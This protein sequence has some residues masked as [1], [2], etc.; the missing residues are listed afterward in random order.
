M[1]RRLFNF[2]TVRRLARHLFAIGS[3][4]LLVAASA[5]WLESYFYGHGLWF[6]G[7]TRAVSIV[8]NRGGCVVYCTGPITY[9]PRWSRRDAASWPASYDQL[10]DRHALGF[11]F[12]LAKPLSSRGPAYGF[13]LP[14]W[15]IVGVLGL[16]AWRA[17]RRS[18]PTPGLCRSCGY[19]LRATPERCPECGAVAKPPHN[20]PMQRTGAAV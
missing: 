10:F 19:D 9:L 7:P 3:A 1:R 15:S 5:A 13:A 17:R 18:P 16:I 14:Y 2:R 6:N 4:V 8:S 12:A 20:P 11:G